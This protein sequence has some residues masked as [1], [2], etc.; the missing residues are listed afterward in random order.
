[1]TPATNPMW[2]RDPSAPVI[3]GRDPFH[4]CATPLVHGADGRWECHGVIH[5]QGLTLGDA[6]V[7]GFLFVVICA[8]IT[9]TVLGWRR[10]AIRRAVT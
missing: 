7:Y 9:A 4:S 10:D 3:V 8:A 2:S 6:A 5:L 1:M